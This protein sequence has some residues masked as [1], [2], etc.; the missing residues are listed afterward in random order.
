VDGMSLRKWLRAK[1]R[2]VDE[3]LAVFRA[4]GEGL[5][6]AHA[7]GVIHRDFKPDNVLVTRDGHALVLDFG[8]ASWVAAPNSESDGVSRSGSESQPPSSGD[9]HDPD[10]TSLT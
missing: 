9:S 3:I 6:A 2:S 1:S 4:A 8:L 7:E 5:A 10:E